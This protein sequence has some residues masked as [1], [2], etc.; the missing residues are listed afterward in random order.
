MPGMLGFFGIDP[1]EIDRAA[2]AHTICLH[3]PCESAHFSTPSGFLLIAYRKSDPM[4]GTRHH[5]DDRYI[6]CFSGDSIDADLD[7]WKSIL[8]W[9]SER[10]YS[11]LGQFSGNF[12]VAVID[13]VARQLYLVSDRRAQ[14]P[15]Y[16]QRH[17]GGFGFS[18]A[19]SSFCKLKHAPSFNIKWL[20]EYVYFNFPIQGTTFLHGVVRVPAATVVQCDLSSFQVSTA[21][22]AGIW[23]KKS[24][25]LRGEESFKLAASVFK[26]RIP[27]YYQGSEQIAC[28]LT[29]GWDGRTILAFA[30]DARKIQAYTYGQ[31]G[32]A[33]LTEARKTA[34]YLNVNHR[35]ICFDGAVVKDLPRRMVQALYLS[36]GLERATRGLLPYVYETLTDAGRTYPLTMSGISLD[37]QFRGH[38]LSPS[39]V[40]PSMAKTFSTGDASVD[41]LFWSRVF[42]SDFA[43][44]S[45]HIREQLEYLEC[46]FGDFSSGEHHLLYIL[47]E[48]GP[49]YFSGELQL[50]DNFTTVR[51]PAWDNHIIELCLGI[52]EST[53][54]YSQFTDHIRGSVSERQLQA[55]ILKTHAPKFARIPIGNAR[56]E[57]LLYPRYI[58]LL[59]TMVGLPKRMGRRIARSIGLEP[60]PLEGWDR[61]LNVDH[62]DFVNTMLFS[63]ESLIREYISDDFLRNVEPNESRDSYWLG[64]LLNVELLLRL[65]RN[66][67]ETDGLCVT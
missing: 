25:L 34:S 47:Y 16:Y 3:R 33:D 56:P 20:Y 64:K 53:L 4:R 13:K 67:W 29:G 30:P 24:T 11:E 58:Y 51:V 46:N 59:Y 32:C 9:V 52:K 5:E 60:P 41:T 18:T 14:Y 35:Q 54:S 27:L 43:E 22:Y 66:R 10:R 31:P 12:A 36:S 48:I 21:T 7:R 8:Q 44:F 6:A 2:L 1:S 15:L 61:W 42:K 17:R 38:A 19:L 26:E 37:M 45:R 49:H 65:I 55:Y 39:L 50:A 28:A 62:R 40:S 63:N 57:V 23:R